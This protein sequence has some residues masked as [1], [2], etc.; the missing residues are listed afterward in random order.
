MPGA[1]L[2]MEGMGKGVRKV[3][4]MLP[5]QLLQFPIKEEG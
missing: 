5:H 4:R 1:R 2:D 3:S